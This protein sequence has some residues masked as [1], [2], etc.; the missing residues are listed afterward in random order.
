[1]NCASNSI[2][3]YQT[4]FFC[5]D[6]YINFKQSSLVDPESFSAFISTTCINPG[7]LDEVREE[8]VARFY[9]NLLSK[10]INNY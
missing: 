1:M 9:S 4:T 8:E 3:T 2:T 7:F 10:K 6:K 5:K